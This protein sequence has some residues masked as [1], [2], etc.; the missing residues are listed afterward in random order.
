MLRARTSTKKLSQTLFKEITSRVD[1]A[2]QDRSVTKADDKP[3]SYMTNHLLLFCCLF[4]SHHVV[5]ITI[6]HLASPTRITAVELN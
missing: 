2:L 1:A 6:T 3:T 4:K 5:I